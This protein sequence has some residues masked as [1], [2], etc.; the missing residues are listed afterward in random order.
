[1]YLHCGD[2]VD[3]VE[4]EDVDPLTESLKKHVAMVN[5]ELQ[6]CWTALDIFML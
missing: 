6:V 3:V 5:A 4:E 2:R 1:M